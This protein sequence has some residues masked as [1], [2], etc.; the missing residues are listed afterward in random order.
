MRGC[1]G[2]FSTTCDLLKEVHS[3]SDFVTLAVTLGRRWYCRVG[4]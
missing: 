1:E 2:H 4:S 3:S